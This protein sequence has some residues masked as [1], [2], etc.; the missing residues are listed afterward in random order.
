MKLY[1]GSR[2]YW[3]AAAALTACLLLWTPV[4]RAV[5]SA[6]L[7]FS[8]Q[9]LAS[10]T[11][12]Q[13]TAIKES[14]IRNS[15][16]GRDYEALLYC[17]ARSEPETA[18]ILIAGLSELGCYHPRLVALS[19]VLAGKGLMVITPDIRE[20]RD[21]QITAEPIEQILFWY[22]Q[23]PHLEKGARIRKT[24]LAGISYSGTL[25]LITAA[26]PEIRDS[27]GF[28]AALGPYCSL[29]RCTRNWFAAEAAAQPG[30]AYPT[31]FY[32]KWIVMRSALAMVA[33][34]SDRVFLQG[35]LDNL[36]LQKQV[37]PASPELS[38]E[39]KR[40]YGLATMPADRSNPELAQEIEKYLVP[41]LFSQIEPETSLGKIKCPVF[42]IHGTHDDL[43][44][45]A[46][47]VELHRKLS[48]S[49]L[50]IS[51]FLTHTHPTST[52]LTFR[53]K[54]AALIDTL[55]FCYQLSRVIL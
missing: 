21:F 41:R 8:F 33:S 52:P 23:A 55:I 40:W 16:Y 9:Q 17:P 1:S 37:P 48:N 13:S 4:R 10:G 30:D 49:H 29:L 31:K 36:L 42:L 28:V 44:P 50:L 25:A 26:K 54:A 27:V 24:G 51:P 39:G 15:Y 46:E 45:P 35:L 3:V 32:A 34:P 14:K 43:I 53:Q 7:A 6:R 11:M 22:R 19:R 18:V 5:F 47:S 38:A 2:K 12:E 20:F